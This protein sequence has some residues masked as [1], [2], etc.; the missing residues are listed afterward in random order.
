MSKYVYTFKNLPDDLFLI[1]LFREVE[2]GFT[3]IKRQTGTE[4]ECLKQIQSWKAWADPEP[5][6]EWRIR[7]L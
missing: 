2:K 6:T 1:E 4:I 3:V 7:N 5:Y